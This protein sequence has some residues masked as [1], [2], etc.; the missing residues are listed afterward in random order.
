MR[1]VVV[2]LVLFTSCNFLKIVDRKQEKRFAREEIPLYKFKDEQG[3]HS[4]HASNHGRKKVMMIHGYGASGI[5]QYYRSAILL[6]EE[7][8]VILPDLL[9]CGRSV[10]DGI[11]YSI[12]AQVEHVK[13]I[14]DSLH[15]SEPLLLIGNSYGGIVSAYFAE[16]YPEHISK[17]IIY[18]SP[19]NEY[20]SSYADSLAHTLEVPSVKELLAPT[21]IRE[22][23]ISLDLIFNDQPYIP[24]FLRRQM[25]KY[26]SIPARPV[27][28]KL[29]DHLITQEAEMNAH[30]FKWK[31]PV[32]ICWGEYDV[33]IP[34]STCNGIMKRYSL[35]ADRLHVFPKAAHAANVEYPKEFVAYVTRQM[36]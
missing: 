18:D 35:P 14:L 31:M 24:R 17:L 11:D 15:V 13:T 34:M 7:Y 26:G 4:V 30:Y 28:L 10:G 22:N 8:D 2:L 6:N 3:T 12:E 23:R 1:N 9:Y 36:H 20:S 25:V 19:V 21:T 29:L 33:L 32:H 16:K 27:Q 5:G